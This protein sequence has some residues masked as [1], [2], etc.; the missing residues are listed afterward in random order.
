M[1]IAEMKVNIGI[2][3]LVYVPPPDSQVLSLSIV[4]GVLS[5]K[6][7]IPDNW[8]ANA[9]VDELEQQWQMPPVD[10]DQ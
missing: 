6:L 4:D 5:V 3:P 8:D 2:N 1:K 10:M 7:R 9:V